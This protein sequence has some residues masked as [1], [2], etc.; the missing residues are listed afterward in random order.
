MKF[1][2]RELK[3]KGDLSW[4]EKFSYDF[5]YYKYKFFFSLFNIYNSISS[6]FYKTKEEKLEEENAD[7]VFE[8]LH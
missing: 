7:Y 1:I 2:Y 8:Y 6:F 4:Y 5:E 3:S